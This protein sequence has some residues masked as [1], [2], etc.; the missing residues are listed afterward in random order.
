MVMKTAFFVL[1]M[2][3][4]TNTM[5]EIYKWTD[6]QGNVHYSDKPV[7]DNAQQLQIK[8]EDSNK[9]RMTQQE[10]L[11][12]RQR[13]LQAYDEDRAN[14]KETEAREQKQ[15]ENL[16]R[17]CVVAKDRLARYERSRGIYDLDKDGNRV[18]LSDK[19]Q[20]QMKETLRQQINQHCN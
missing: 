14:K 20:Q 3:C 13:L 6:E 11:E 16:Q 8:T 5:A 2:F 12:R 10:R 15:K 7:Q 4:Y 1:L 19:D 9:S 18:M 17:Q